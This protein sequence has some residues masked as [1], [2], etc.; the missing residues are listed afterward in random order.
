MDDTAAK[1]AVGETKPRQA[2]HPEVPAPEPKGYRGLTLKEAAH[3]TPRPTITDTEASVDLVKMRAYRLGRLR[4]QLVR[5]DIA[6]CVLLSPYSI[7]YATGVRNC[8]IFQTHIPAG[9]LFVP[10]EGPT[11]YIDSPPGLFTAKDLETVDETRIDVLPLSYMFA[12]DRLGEWSK[13][14]ARQI[15][16]LL[17]AHG[18]LEIDKTDGFLLLFDDAETALAYAQAYHRG[19]AALDP[20][21]KARAGL[22]VGGVILRENPAED[23]ARVA[24][25][26]KLEGTTRA[27]QNTLRVGLKP[28]L[29]D[30][31]DNVFKALDRIAEISGHPACATGCDMFFQLESNFVLDERLD[32]TEQAISVGNRAAF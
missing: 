29:G 19:I 15:A 24:V 10:A 16:D 13:K 12:S 17:A 21:L 20:P 4:E 5:N 28:E 14:F 22:H 25:A 1:G 3:T 26:P 6:A 2:G 9:Y 7:R 23:V 18:G 32:V 30:E 11:V 27:A 8:A 31:I